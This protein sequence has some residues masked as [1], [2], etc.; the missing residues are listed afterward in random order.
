MF[1]IFPAQIINPY[2]KNL[3]ALLIAV[4]GTGKIV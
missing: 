1:F 3:A 4:S 2:Q